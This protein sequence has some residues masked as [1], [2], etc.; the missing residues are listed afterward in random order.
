[1]GYFNCN[2]DFGKYK[3]VCNDFSYEFENGV[4]IL[5]G[6]IASGGWALSYA[7]SCFDKSMVV[8][9]T[10]GKPEFIL[11]GEQLTLEK[12]RDK[13]CYLSGTERE[14][15]S[16][17]IKCPVRKI[18]CKNIKKNKL[19]L[20]E[21]EIRYTFFITASRFDRYIKHVGNE[22]YACRAAIGYSENREIYCFPWIGKTLMKGVYT[23]IVHLC[24]ILNDLGK[25]VILPTSCDFS[26]NKD[27]SDAIIINF[28]DQL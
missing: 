20:T 12:L 25:I 10:Y 22:R 14:Y 21:N 9:P 15:V 27:F 7:L 16:E 13:S 8:S 17:I 3:V 23:Q 1:M 28:D 6:D 19:N 24:N 26:E 5:Q 4:Y 2:S 11:N 18:V